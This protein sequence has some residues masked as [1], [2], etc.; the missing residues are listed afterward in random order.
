MATFVTQRM[1]FVHVPKTGGSWVTEAVR[2]AGVPAW[3]PA[4]TSGRDDPV[5]AHADLRE[6]AASDR[7]SVAFVRHPLDWWRSYWGHR[8]RAGWD[9]ASGID[10]AASDDFNEFVVKVLDRGE[11]SFDRVVRRFVGLPSPSVDFV[12][13][14]EHLLED[15]CDALRLAGEEFSTDA[16]TRLAPANANDYGR[17]PAAYRPEVAARLAEAERETIERFYADDPVPAGLILGADRLP[18]HARSG[19]R[20]ATRD[21]ECLEGRVRALERA[22]SLSRVAET[23]LELALR[24]AHAE[25]DQ[26]ACALAS[27]RGS[28]LV[29]YTRTARTAYYRARRADRSSRPR[30]VAVA[31]EPRAQ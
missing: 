20:S 1:I 25:R 17:F 15:T 22:L 8:M 2:S 13:R 31:D 18:R 19:H 11:W 14:F 7:F 21:V 4:P 6:V 24:T 26:T 3:A 10:D 29:R 27:L 12:G 30:V 28:R 16:I 5:H 9:P 23:R